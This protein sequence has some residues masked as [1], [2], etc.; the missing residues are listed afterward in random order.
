LLN[1]LDFFSKWGL[2]P[3][4]ASIDARSPLNSRLYVCTHFFCQSHSRKLVA[5]KFRWNMEGST[6][7]HLSNAH[8]RGGFL[9]SGS[10]KFIIYSGLPQCLHCLKLWFVK[11]IY[12]SEIIDRC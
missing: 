11:G 10:D 2:T 5:R 8:L 12:W 9:V 4:S 1:L 3:A 7:Q 6:S